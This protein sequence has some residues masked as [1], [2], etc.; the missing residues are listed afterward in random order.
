M[1]LTWKT[2]YLCDFSL[3]EGLDVQEMILV[4][5]QLGEKYGHQG[6]FLEA[7]LEVTTDTVQY[8]PDGKPLLDDKGDPVTVKGPNPKWNPR[9]WAWFVVLMHRRAGHKDFW[10]EDVNGK[11]GDLDAEKGAGELELIA[12]SGKDESTSENQGV[13]VAKRPPVKRSASSGGSGGTPPHS[14]PASD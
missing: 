7:A 3:E 4:S 1:R 8:G 10:I 11:L 2:D 13:T 9:A 14:T 12:E 5:D 6:V